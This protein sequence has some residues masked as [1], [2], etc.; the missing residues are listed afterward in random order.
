MCVYHGNLMP[1]AYIQ[2][3]M[4]GD[5]SQNQED[6]D[7]IVEV[8]SRDFMAALQRLLVVKEKHFQQNDEDINPPQNSP[9]FDKNEF[10]LISILE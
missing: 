9:F 4:I 2:Q 6:E 7:D 1:C 10:V 8:N 5:E 3:G